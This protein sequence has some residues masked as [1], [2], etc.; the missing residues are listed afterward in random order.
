MF[1]AMPIDILSH[2]G[3]LLRDLH[4]YRSSSIALPLPEGLYRGKAAS[5]S[6]YL[7]KR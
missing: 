7:T 6:S 4:V 3:W 2:A 5:L 1:F